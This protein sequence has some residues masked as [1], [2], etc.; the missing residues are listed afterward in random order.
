[1]KLKIQGCE[2]YI[3]ELYNSQVFI[4]KVNDAVLVAHIIGSNLYSSFIYVST[5]SVCMTF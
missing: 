1:M 3:S 5:I 4:V 2:W